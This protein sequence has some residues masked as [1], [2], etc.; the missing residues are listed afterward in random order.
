MGGGGSRD[1][2]LREPLVLLET[3]DEELGV[4]D[5]N[6]PKDPARALGVCVA[7]EAPR[8]WPRPRRRRRP[9]SSPWMCKAFWAI[10]V[11]PSSDAASPAEELV[12]AR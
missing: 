10:A 9:W 12:V 4:L 6:A 3:L 11:A 8:K 2:D 7:H 1:L 5:A